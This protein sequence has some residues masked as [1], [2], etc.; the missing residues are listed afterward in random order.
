MTKSTGV[1][2]ANGVDRADGIGAGIDGSTGN[3]LQSIGVGREFR[4]D[5]NRDRG[6][7]GLD[8]FKHQ[9]R[10]LPHGHTQAFGVWARQI[11]FKAVRVRR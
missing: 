7:N 10:V 6:F 4:Y 1:A 2:R 9:I 11:K 5:R 3:V 8:D